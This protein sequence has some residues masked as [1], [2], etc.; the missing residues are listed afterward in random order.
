MPYTLQR[1]FQADLNINNNLLM[2]CKPARLLRASTH[3][4]RVLWNVSNLFLF[5]ARIMWKS[6]LYRL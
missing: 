6:H 4:M 1:L 2:L 5:V 3:F